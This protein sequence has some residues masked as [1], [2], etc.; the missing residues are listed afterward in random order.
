MSSWVP[1][2]VALALLLAVGALS[3]PAPGHAGRVRQLPP[4]AGII[5]DDFNTACAVPS[6][7]WTFVDPR[8]DSS[9]EI[10]GVGTS[11]A[12]LQ[13][14]V[15]AGT[16][17]DQWTN[18]DWAPRLLQ[19][20]QDANFTVDVK[21]E[22][23][24]SLQYQSQGI[25]VVD[26]ASNMLRFDFYSDG[27]SVH[28]FAA[29]IVNG[30]GAV[31]GLSTITP[32]VPLWMRIRRSGD[33]WTQRYSYDGQ[34]WTTA[35]TFSHT[36][37]AR[38][39]GVF[40][41]ND[42]TTPG[43]TP[44]HT[45][46]F[47]YF[48]DALAP[49]VPE[50]GQVAG[51]PGPKILDTL[52]DGGGSVDR[53]P[54]LP[55]YSCGQ[56]VTV[57]AVPDPGQEFTGWTGDATGTTNPLV[58]AMTADRTLEAH[59][60]PDGTP[61]V[62]SS[63]HVSAGSD[64]AMIH[65]ST[66]EPATSAVAHG[67]TTAYELGTV[68]DPTLVTSHAITLL[69]LDPDMLYHYQITSVDG[70]GNPTSTSDLTF[71]TLPPGSGGPSGIVSDDFN[72][73]NLD[74]G[75]WEFV[76][77]L[78]D[79]TVRVLDV[80]TTGGKAS[81]SVPAGTKHFVGPLGIS[82]PRLRQAANDTDFIVDA[83]FTSALTAATQEQG[84]LI[85]E[86]PSRFLRFDFYSDGSSLKL[87]SAAYV[88]GTTTTK[89]N[90]TLPAM[91]PMYMRVERIG[92]QW[93]LSYSPDGSIWTPATSFSHTMAVTAVSVW[94][95]NEGNPAPSHVA[96]VDYFFNALSPIVPEDGAV[97][98]DTVPPWIQQVGT[99][100]GQTT[101][102][103]HW[104]TDEPSTSEVDFGP[105]TSYGTSVSDSALVYDHLVLLTNLTPATTYQYRVVSVDPD[106]NS[107]EQAGLSFT[108]QSAGA[109]TGPAIDVWYGPVQY[110]GQ[111]GLPQPIVNILG[112]VSDPDGVA[113]LSY[114]LNGGASRTL[115]IGPNSFRLQ[116]AG[117]FNA[118]IQVTDLVDGLNTVQIQASDTLGN[119]SSE[120]VTV[121]YQANN[122]WP[123]PYTLDWGALPTI[124]AGAQVIDGLWTLE[125][126]TIRPVELGYDRLVAI[127][128]VAW[129]DYELTVPI[130]LWGYDLAGFAYPSNRPA[131]GV[132][133]RWVGHQSN[134]KQPADGLN[135]LGACE[136]YRINRADASPPNS[137]E[138]WT[139][140]SATT[141]S[142]ILQLDFGVTY[143]WKAR[144][145]TTALGP[146]YS[147]KVWRYG[148]PEPAGWTVQEQQPLS[149]LGNGSLLILAG[150]VDA[151]FGPVTVTPLP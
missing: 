27:T 9:Y 81:I 151:S 130:T 146:L 141:P 98:P 17:H 39:V 125:G 52:V 95:G 45:A 135:P 4:K 15:P 140:D 36:L 42:G 21:F 122:V 120:L 118:D 85:E 5:S 56:T 132:C 34:N 51:D 23:P 69:D 19:S 13:I 123:L 127:G 136:I 57:T 91:T 11:D 115:S 108:T 55:S 94:A 48:F 41:L 38:Q 133:L 65:W 105:T 46:V 8:G 54:D 111:I 86:S 139:L 50:D 26:S 99:T 106:T 2:R 24:L 129:T 59:F 77:P 87:F 134:G 103:V 110:F 35:V 49:I 3:L 97:P 88:D 138:S 102:Q 83:G 6:G 124:D 93:N 32:G 121:D 72:Q 40:A 126:S 31:R 147:V 7:F 113:S 70:A 96:T 33:Q 73:Q 82:A 64:A 80:G 76:D 84:L 148:D 29:S 25:L 143:W 60:I 90:A 61:P 14:H 144:V 112:N 30:V 100:I 150:Y 89:L 53:A 47:D 10:T 62:V 71:Q 78:G 131:L 18:K 63:V 104:T 68:S 137:L 44:A 16:S 109:T 67:P 119:A 12:Q 74:Q 116:N 28:I 22:S 142:A 58:L 145:E 92:N 107:A 20:I 75:L 101:V 37:V 1:S 114:R 79:A 117:D 66:N 43:T 149:A 128:D